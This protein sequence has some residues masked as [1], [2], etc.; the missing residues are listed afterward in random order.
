[1]PD[2]CRNHAV[3]WARRLIVSGRVMRIKRIKTIYNSNRKS[4]IIVNL[5]QKMFEML[6][7]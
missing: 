2:Q 4:I 1:M 3:V 7:V 5:L 6:F